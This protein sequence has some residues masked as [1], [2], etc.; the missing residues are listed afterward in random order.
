MAHFVP[1]N[2][3]LHNRNGRPFSRGKDAVGICHRSG[4][5]YPY[6]DLKFE[7][8][9]GYLVHKSEN[10]GDHS[11]VNHP[12]NYPPKKLVDRIALKWSLPEVA[13]S[14][15]TIVS[16]D[17]LYLPSHASTFYTSTGTVTSIGTGVSGSSGTAAAA[18]FSSARNSQYVL[19]VFQ[20]I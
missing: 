18:K 2:R 9:T 14:I 16:A 8:G 15:G 4:F 20:G 6:T 12:Q 3:N 5:K 7:P 19:V 1:I 10:D 13:L 17:Q 11:L